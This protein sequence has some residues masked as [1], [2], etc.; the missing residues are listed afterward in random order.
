MQEI[1]DLREVA[2]MI[3]DGKKIAQ[4]IQEDLRKKIADLG[5][6]PVLALV[7]VGE[8][9][10]IE[11]FVRK[12]KKFAEIIG[13]HIEEHRFSETIHTDTLLGKVE[14]LSLDPSVHGI[15]VQLPLPKGVD[16]GTV[17]S[18]I[19]PEKDVDVISHEGMTLFESGESLVLPPVVGAMKEILDRGGVSLSGKKV[20]IVGQGRLVGKPAEIWF[21]NLGMDVT[22][23]TRTSTDIS[24]D[25]RQA[26]ILV[27]GAGSPSLVKPDMIKDGVVIL[28]AGTSEE[29]GKLAGD[30]DSLCAS[31]A[32]LMT[33]VPGGI[34]PITVAVLFRNLFVLFL[35]KNK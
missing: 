26:D 10:V 22:V 21:K 3:I 33:P 30:A 23:L 24:E 32:S 11:S 5:H 17:L 9:P 15:V 13:V 25:I 20:V 35:E 4:D 7:V 19:S 14:E 8:D 12:K 34:G 1:S 16:S 2:G 28:D 6:A 29:K 31:K 18:A 27:L